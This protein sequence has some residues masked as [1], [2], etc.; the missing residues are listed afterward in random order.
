MTVGSCETKKLLGKKVHKM[1]I[2]AIALLKILSCF[3]DKK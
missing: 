3:F 1:G 2:E